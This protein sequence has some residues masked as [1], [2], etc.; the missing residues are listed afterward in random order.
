MR[1]YIEPRVYPE[2]SRREM[3]GSKGKNHIPVTIPSL[4]PEWH[5]ADVRLEYVFI[6]SPPCGTSD[7]CYS[8]C[9]EPSSLPVLVSLSIPS[10]KPSS[11]TFNGLSPPSL[12]STSPLSSPFLQ[13]VFLSDFSPFERDHSNYKSATYAITSSKPTLFSLRFQSDFAPGEKSAA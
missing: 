2:P 7:F 4:C 13:R 12:T 6:S 10:P 11:L 1:V 5:I 3:N 8:V 9:P